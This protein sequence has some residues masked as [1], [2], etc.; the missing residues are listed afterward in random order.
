L[1]AENI[2]KGRW[3]EA[4]SHIK[5][6]NY[7]WNYYLHLF[8]EARILT[9]SDPLMLTDGESLNEICVIIQD[10]PATISDDQFKKLFSLL[11]PDKQKYINYIGNCRVHRNVSE[12][13]SEHA[14]KLTISQLKTMDFDEFYINILGSYFDDEDSND[15]DD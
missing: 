14:V 7:W 9:K 8:P 1:Y 11:F 10:V 2:I 5:K 15:F 3:K 13:E 12:K 6:D 4:E